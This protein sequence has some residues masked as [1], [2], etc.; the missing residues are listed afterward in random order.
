[1]PLLLSLLIV[2]VVIAVVYWLLTTIPL[3]AQLVFLR[4]LIPL[5]LILAALIWVWPKLGVT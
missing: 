1:M 3:P 4:W 5:I 2:A